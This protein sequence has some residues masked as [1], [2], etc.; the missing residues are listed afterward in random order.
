MSL[1]EDYMLQKKGSMNWKVLQQKQ[2]RKKKEH[3]KLN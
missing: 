1:K 2:N 3:K